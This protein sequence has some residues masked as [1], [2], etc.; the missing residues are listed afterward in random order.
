MAHR[1][2]YRTT[3]RQPV[4]ATAYVRT[5]PTII[6]RLTGRRRVR[7]TSSTRAKP[8]SSRRGHKNRHNH[9]H[10]HHTDRY[11]RTEPVYVS[12]AAP[13]HHYRRKPTLGDKIAGVIMRIRGTLTGRPGL[14]KYSSIE[15]LETATTGNV[16]CIFR[17]RVYPLTPNI[18]SGISSAGVRRFVSHH[19]TKVRFS[20]GYGLVNVGGQVQDITTI[21][22]DSKAASSY[23]VPMD[24]CSKAVMTSR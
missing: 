13:A 3:A 15:Y 7:G 6:D 17:A 1:T 10:H 21:N 4:T 23:E 9:H 24:D 20:D 11:S 18:A 2:H 22:G 16:A 12:S 14:K 19:T 5:K 8:A